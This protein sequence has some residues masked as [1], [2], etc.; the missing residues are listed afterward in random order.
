MAFCDFIKPAMKLY[1]SQH[2]SNDLYLTMV[3]MLAFVSS[4]MSKFIWGVIQD[5]LGFTKVYA[6]ILF[7]DFT[8]CVSLDFVSYNEVLYA[9]WIFFIFICEGAH[10]VIFP[11]VCSA[12]YGSKLGSRVYSFVY[13]GRCM[14]SSI[15]I[16][17][18][19][20]IMPKYG[21]FASFLFFADLIIVAVILL[22]FFNERPVPVGEDLADKTTSLSSQYN[23]RESEKL[24]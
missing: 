24:E 18:S 16:F 11:S 20:V 2:H 3:G 8:F 17:A 14:S 1:G 4:S 12:I 7:L 22:I 15:G 23:Q 5:H 9:I 13:F 19:R 6:V 21:W 10:F